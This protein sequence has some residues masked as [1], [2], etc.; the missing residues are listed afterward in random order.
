MKLCGTDSTKFVQ[1]TLSSTGTNFQLHKMVQNFALSEPFKVNVHA[2]D[3]QL[4]H[5]AVFQLLSFNINQ[6]TLVDH[7]NPGLLDNLSW[8]F[9]CSSAASLAF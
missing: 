9:A 4:Q 7:T 2:Q 6:T 3:I 1:L 8:I 5:F